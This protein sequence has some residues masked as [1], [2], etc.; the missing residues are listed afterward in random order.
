MIGLKGK[1][2]AGGVAGLVMLIMFG[3][4]KVQAARLETARLERDVAQEAVMKVNAAM[5]GMIEQRALLTTALDLRE[6]ELR[7]SRAETAALKGELRTISS[8]VPDEKWQDCRAVVVPAALIERLF[9]PAPDG[10]GG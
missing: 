10:G 8:E 7:R 4:F 3:A 5:R 9:L 1:L 2:I 6:R